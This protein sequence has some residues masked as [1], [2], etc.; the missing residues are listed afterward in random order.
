MLAEFL[1]GPLDAEAV[2]PVGPNPTGRPLIASATGPRPDRERKCVADVGGS[3]LQ[4]TSTRANE[5]EIQSSER[6]TQECVNMTTSGQ[7]RMMMVRG[8]NK[9]PWLAY[10]LNSANA[11]P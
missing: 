6:P 10:N 2:I 11:T 4:A 8:V 7:L 1:R 5:S 3:S 9:D